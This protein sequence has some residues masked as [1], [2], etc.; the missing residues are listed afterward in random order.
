MTFEEAYEKVEFL[1]EMKL[2]FPVKISG[3]IIS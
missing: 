3:K 1:T 2:P